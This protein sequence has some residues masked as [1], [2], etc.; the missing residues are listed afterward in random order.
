MSPVQIVS[1]KKTVALT[2]T[3]KTACGFLRK[4]NARFDQETPTLGQ[5]SVNGFRL[6]Q[7]FLRACRPA[8]D[9]RKPRTNR[10]DTLMRLNTPIAATALVGL[11]F[12]V[13][14]A[15]SGFAAEGP[16]ATLPGVSGGLVVQLGGAKTDLAAALSRTG[17]YLVNVLERSDDR[18]TE[19]R[20]HLQ[21]AGTYGLASVDRLTDPSRLP[22]AENLVNAILVEDF[23]LPPAE[24]HR[25]LVPRGIVIAANPSLI[26]AKQLAEAGFESV[27]DATL[28]DGRAV[29]VARK[30]WPNGMDSWSHPRH[31]ADGNAVSGDLLVGPPERVRWIAAATNEV[32]GMVTAGGR[33][34][35]GGLLARDSF[36]GLRLWHHDLSKAELNDGHFTLPQTPR[37]RPIASFDQVFAVAKGR[38]VALDAVTGKV[39]REFAG[40]SRPLEI[41]HLEDRLIASEETSVRVFD[42]T[43]GAELWSFQA[44][45]PRNVVAGHGLVALIHGRARR[46]ETLEAVAL[47]LATGNI[48]WKRSDFDWLPKVTRTVLHADQLAFELSS[49]TDHEAGNELRI[50]SS[51]TGEP[52]WDKTF[53]PGMNHRRQA[54]AMYLDSGLWI[55]HGGKVNTADKDK[56]TRLPVEVSA[57]DP[58]TGKTLITHEAGLAHCFPPVATPNYVFAGTFDLTDLKSGYTVANR[59]TKANCSTENGWVPANGLVYTTPK[60]CTCWPMLRGFVSLAPRA[61]DDIKTQLPSEATQHPLETGPAKA[62]PNAADPQAS[63][64]PLYRHDRWRSGSSTAPGPQKLDALWSVQLATKAEVAAFS[65]EPGGPIFHDW[66]ENPII[67]GP[68]SAPTIANGLVYVTRPNAHEVIAVEAG[69]G[70]VRWRF[71]ANGRVDTPP[72]LHRGLCLFGSSAGSVYALR[73]DTGERVWQLQAAP[74]NDRIVAYGQVESPWPVPGAVLIIDDVAYFAAGRQPLADG[75]ILVF[76]VDSLTGNRHWVHRIETVPQQGDYENS[77]LEFDPFDILHQEG[78]RIAMSRWLISLDG[79]KTDVDKWNAFAR[80]NTGGGTAYVP[81]GS[82]T[83]G[84]RHQY[85]FPGEA[86]RRP[87]AVCRDNTVFTSLDGTTKLFRRDFNLEQGEMFSSKWIT[88]WEAATKAR[89]GGTPYRSYRLAEKASWTAD[90]FA[91]TEEIAQP[92]KIGEQLYND[93]HAMALSGDGRLFVAHRDGRLK[94][95]ATQDGQLLTETRIPT[96]AW[97][98]MAIAGNHLFLTTQTGELICL[99][100]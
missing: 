69:T 27:E 62:D 92:K 95:I 63:D 54:R 60:H 8:F 68:L 17:R 53:P 65:Q 35:Y 55:L 97:D 19:A 11:A 1:G 47:D 37:T 79:K 87:L 67:K 3:T 70:S 52:L 15:S 59:I 14:A 89:E 2:V 23:S 100:E 85:R 49:M 33:N 25:T 9:M 21:P 61:A 50:V 74:N 6:G 7:R 77:A 56:M 30:P 99:G 38:L 78:D 76:A 12:L 93:L 10:T 45:E 46:G 57:L 36:N 88:G 72:A 42:S 16:S 64:W 58:S 39:V 84:A 29:V 44:G 22:Y 73:A 90:L 13:L 32:E 28:A 71:T 4:G 82:W 75:G 34:F 20:T 98:G 31:A 51:Q 96:P 80:I 41:V 26:S 91:K 43:T 24:L 48:K 86:N 81:R 18:V 66:R 40:I 5:S 94:S 83:Y